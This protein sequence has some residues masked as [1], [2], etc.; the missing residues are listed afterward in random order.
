MP[1]MTDLRTL[2]ATART[3]LAGDEAAL[4]AELLL[5]VAL[6]HPRSWLYAHADAVPEGGRDRAL[7]GADRAPRRR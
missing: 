4:E 7:C 3:Q 1:H 6:G 2:L 5:A